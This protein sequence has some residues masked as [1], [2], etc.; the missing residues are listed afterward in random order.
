M[1]AFACRIWC[2][3]SRHFLS[4]WGWS[5]GSPPVKLEVASPGAG[6]SKHGDHALFHSD[7]PSLLHMQSM[8]S[9]DKRGKYE[10]VVVLNESLLPRG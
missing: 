2:R 5:G 10:A 3:R 9:V 4:G 7:R 1:T 6:F 8:T